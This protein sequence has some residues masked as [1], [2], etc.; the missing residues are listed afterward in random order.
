MNHTTIIA[1]LRAAATHIERAIEA[2]CHGDCQWSAHDAGE[3]V[4]KCLRELGAEADAGRLEKARKR[5]AG[6]GCV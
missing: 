6:R 3:Y 4:V 1:E 2:G 5:M